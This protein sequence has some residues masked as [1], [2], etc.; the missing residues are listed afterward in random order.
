MKELPYKL[1]P[2]YEYAPKRS[3]H[4]IA[5]FSACQKRVDFAN[6]NCNFCPLQ[7]IEISS[8]IFFLLKFI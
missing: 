8:D 5:R 1:N 4:K 2:V 6:D 7:T 3:N